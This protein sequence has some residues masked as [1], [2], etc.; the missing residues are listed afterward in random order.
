MCIMIDSM[1]ELER[2]GRG[3]RH[4]RH[5]RRRMHACVAMTETILLILFN[6]FIIKERP[7]HCPQHHRQR[8]RHRETETKTGGK[9]ERKKERRDTVLRTCSCSRPSTLCPAD[10]PPPPV[11]TVRVQQILRLLDNTNTIHVRCCQCPIASYEE[12]DTCMFD[13]ACS[14]Y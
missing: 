6:F 13:S 1:R 2:K 7:R 10:P 11:P 8:Q 4:A 5:M 12:E 3:D 14:R 9:K